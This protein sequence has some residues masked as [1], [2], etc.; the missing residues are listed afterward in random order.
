MRTPRLFGW[1]WGRGS[2]PPP[3]RPVRG[4]VAPAAIHG[5]LDAYIGELPQD[6]RQRARPASTQTWHQEPIRLYRDT[7]RDERV[8]AALDQRLD[9]LVAKAWNVE[10]GG[11]R[12]LDQDA[13]DDLQAQLDT[14][15]FDAIY[16][17]LAHATWYGYAI[18]EMIWGRSGGRVIIEDIRVRSPDRFR[19]NAGGALQLVNQTHPS[20]LPV[21]EGKFVVVRRSGEHGDLPWAPGLARW[22][23]WPVMLK[24]QVIRY[25]ALANQ[26]FASPVPVGEYPPGATAGEIA[27]LKEIVVGFTTA[28]AAVL[29]EGQKINLLESLRRSGGDYVDLV[30]YLDRAVTTTVLGQSSTTDQGPWRGTAEV[31]KDVRDEVIVADARMV[32]GALNHS[33]A[34]WMTTWNWPGAAPPRIVRD[35]EPP[36]DLD[37]RA[38]REETVSRTAGIRPTRAH[39]EGVYGGVWEDAPAPPVQP[40]RTGDAGPMPGRGLELAG[41]GDRDAVSRAVEAAIARDGWEPF[42]APV[43]EPIIAAA[44]SAADLD[45]FRKEIPGLFGDMDPSVLAER[46]HRMTF[47]GEMSEA[48]GEGDG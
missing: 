42:M 26:R 33:I 22:C 6:P 14:V 19:W 40:P 48:G 2:K 11:D 43:I 9:A 27:N 17:Q 45:S 5:L 3:G 12:P 41:G 36:E 1:G 31:Q 38:K 16:R 47:S 10:A 13:A 20:G 25:W 30:T 8:M 7:L 32:D 21:P 44:G 34:R 18:A 37:R 29:P 24:R 15:S 46:L 4:E 39:V 35:T 23:Y 28:G